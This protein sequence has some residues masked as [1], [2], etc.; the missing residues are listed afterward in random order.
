MQNR[1]GLP[2]PIS[3]IPLHLRSTVALYCYRRGNLEET[4][5]RIAATCDEEDLVFAGGRAGSALLQIEIALFKPG[6]SA[7]GDAF[8]DRRYRPLSHGASC[9]A[10]SAFSAHHPVH[11]AVVPVATH[12]AMRVVLRH[13]RVRL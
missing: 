8:S 7:A 9:R 1:S 2:L 4:A 12:H 6:A 3:E 5:V 10:A 11:S 13:H